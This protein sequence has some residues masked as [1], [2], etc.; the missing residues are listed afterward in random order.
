MMNSIKI[1]G[2]TVNTWMHWVTRTDKDGRS[3]DARS[4]SQYEISYTEYDLE[5][6]EVIA[7]GTEDFSPERKTNTLSSY[8]VWTWDGKR[9]NKGGCRFF[10]RNGRVTIK[11]G[12]KQDAL[13]IIKTWYPTAALVELRKL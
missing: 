10:D 7:K 3:W 1:Y 11:T 12:T 13:K 6:A 5:D 4:I 9:Y 2:K 8:E